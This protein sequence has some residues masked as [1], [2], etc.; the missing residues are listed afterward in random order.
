M[1]LRNV[2]LAISV[3]VLTGCATPY[4]QFYQDR[5]DEVDVT[6]RP[7][8]YVVTGEEPKL[9][10]GR[11][12]TEDALR[13]IEDGYEMIG[14]SSFNAANVDSKQALQQ[15]KNVHACVV[16]VYSQ[17]TNTVSGSMPLTLPDTQTSTTNLSGTVYG[18]G[19]TASYTGTATS[20]TYGTKTTYI[21]YNVDRYDHFATFWVKTTRP[22]FG[23]SVAELSTETRQRVGTNKGIEVKAVIKGSPAFHADIL[24]G[25]VIIR[26]GEIEVYDL[27]SFTNA[28]KRYAGGKTV[29]R[30][31][32]TTDTKTIPVTLNNL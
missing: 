17:Y 21:P 11:A 19:G 25:D 3:A 22:I 20:T 27:D 18:A 4:A 13:M 14:Y 26:I 23:V 24:R 9:Y 8:R 16:L 28:V 31:L 12:E 7:D 32:R 6:S 10:A 30:V 29:V 5:T 1:Y 2:I 15:A